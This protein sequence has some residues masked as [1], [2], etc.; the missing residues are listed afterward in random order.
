MLKAV[1]FDLDG[2]LLPMD[3]KVFTEGYFKFLI[4]KVAPLGYEPKK[5]IDVIWKGTYLMVKND[6]RKTN[7]EVFWDYFYSVYGKEKEKDKAVFDD[8]YRNEFSKASV[9]CKKNPLAKEI[10]SFVHSQGL[11]AIL[12]TNPF[13]PR[14]GQR[15][16]LSFISLDDTDF[17]YVTDYS[18]SS[19]CKPN[20][21]YFRSLLQK[22]NLLP[23]EV[24]LFGNNTLED[25]DCASSCGI[26]TY[27]VK[28]F[29]IHSDKA[30]G[31]YP[32]IGMEGVMSVIEEEKK[33]RA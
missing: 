28:G 22:R 12:S 32:E 29:I 8:F 30:K 24:I 25:G 18:N 33:A 3:E 20:P 21:M 31:V 4:E 1:F 17:D 5:L 9:F 16:R 11:E 7:E 23:E 27:L 26:K 15:M 6:G 13:F 2:T 10:V 14:D 19:F